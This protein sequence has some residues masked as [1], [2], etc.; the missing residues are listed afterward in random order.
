MSSAALR[1]IPVSFIS[2]VIALAAAVEVAPTASNSARL[3]ASSSGSP[4]GICV[5]LGSAEADVAIEVNTS[6]LRKSA[7]DLYPAFPFL[8]AC[9]ERGVPVT[10]GS[11]AHSPDQVGMDFDL[12]VGLLRRAGITEIATFE[13]RR[14]TVRTIAGD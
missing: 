5:V 10:L 13:G 11:D 12:A 8:A 6:G 4:G 14:R 2:A 3:I 7:L 9:A 1:L